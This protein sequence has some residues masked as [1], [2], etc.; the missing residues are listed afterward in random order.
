MTADDG[1][2]ASGA[3]GNEV[4][5]TVAQAQFVQVSGSSDSVDVAV[6]L[7]KQLPASFQQAIV[8][9][10]GEVEAHERDASM[11]QVLR[12]QDANAARSHPIVTMMKDNVELVVS[13]LKRILSQELQNVELTCSNCDGEVKL[14]TSK[15]CE[16]NE[17]EGACL[18]WWEANR[19]CETNEH[20]D[21][22]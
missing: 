12:R 21:A 13:K 22:E 2:A 5:V 3:G 14:S 20:A 17:S 18:K 10:S 8:Q 11:V 15:F 19:P 7:L 4:S 6:K 1:A 9:T 16:E